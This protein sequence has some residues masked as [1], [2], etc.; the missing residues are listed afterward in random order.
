MFFSE[1]SLLGFSWGFLGCKFT[2]HV[3]QLPSKP[4]VKLHP[5]LATLSPGSSVYSIV[6]NINLLSLAYAFIRSFLCLGGWRIPRRGHG[7]NSQTPCCCC[8]SSS[9]SFP[10]S[11]ASSFRQLQSQCLLRLAGIHFSELAE[12]VKLSKC[13][14]YRTGL[15]H[16]LCHVFL[17]LVA[18]S[19]YLFLSV[20]CVLKC[21]LRHTCNN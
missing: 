19:S 14:G 11:S 3:R 5:K 9:F 1:H 8:C 6:C 7:H 18:I 4:F 21:Y 13:T 2:Q 20:R 16:S 10:T 17:F 12:L 15:P